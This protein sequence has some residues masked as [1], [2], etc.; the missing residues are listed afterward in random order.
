MRP[1]NAIAFV[2]IAAA[3]L[4]LG[5]WALAPAIRPP[6][7]TTPPPV[8]VLAP[9]SSRNEAP[10]VPDIALAQAAYDRAKALA[11]GRHVEGL[12]ID[13]LQCSAISV[14][15][16]LCQIRY[17]RDDET[18]GRL[19]FTVVTLERGSQG[20]TLTNGLCRGDGS[21]EQ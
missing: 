15:R 14:G 7:R 8:G 5:A 4:G 13:D 10:S 12:K 16:Y 6:P 3:A 2:V 18:N 11:R 21:I 1:V 19:H 20:W 17:M 9:L